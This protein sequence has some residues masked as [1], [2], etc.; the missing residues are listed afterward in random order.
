[1]PILGSSYAPTKTLQDSIN[2]AQKFVREMPLTD[3]SLALPIGDW[4]LQFILAPPFSWPWNRVE[5]TFAASQALGQ[6]YTLALPDFGWLESGTAYDGVSTRSLDV[7]TGLNAQT[8]PQ[9]PFVLAAQSVVD[10]NVLFRLTP[11]PDKDY[12]IGI[13]YQKKAP[14]FVA[15]ADTWAPIPDHLS[16]LY[17]SGVLA[18]AYEYA[19]DARYTTWLPLFIR[20]V[21]AAYQGLQQSE[22][23]IFLE[24]RVGEA[25]YQQEQIGNAQMGQRGLGLY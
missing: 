9:Q 14:S 16:Y 5:T 19:A 12:T 17:H 11:Q 18:R 7:K 3:L 23:N 10:G 8:D 22:T 21:I 6:D 13:T 1:M 20:Q 25:R 15:L 24:E 2:Y 4:V